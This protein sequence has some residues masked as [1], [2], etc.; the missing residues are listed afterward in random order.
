MHFLGTDGQEH[1]GVGVGTV[2]L[3][4]NVVLLGGYTFGCHSL[5]HLVGGLFDVFS[6][7]PVRKTAYECV[8]WCNKHHMRWAWF[9]LFGVAGSDVFINLLSRGVISD[10]RIL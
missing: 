5:R 9:S 2:V 6:S 8:S 10:L 3:T 4:L 7:R 1:F